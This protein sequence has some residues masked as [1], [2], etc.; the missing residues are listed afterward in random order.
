MQTRYRLLIVDDE[1]GVRNALTRV[2]RQETYEVITAATGDDALAKARSM[3]I[4]LAI[5]DLMLGG[6]PDG[7]QVM[8]QLLLIQPTVPVIIL[9]AHGTITNAV[10]AMSR[11]AYCYLTKPYKP[12]DVDGPAAARA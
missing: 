12:E 3:V 4:D 6:G 2:F 7:I 1:A 10:E 11:G 8:E 9:T 5:L